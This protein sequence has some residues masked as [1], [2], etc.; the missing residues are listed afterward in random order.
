[1]PAGRPTDCTPELIEQARDYVKDYHVVHGH[2]IPSAVGLCKVINVARST[3]Y[4]WAEEDGSEF[5]DILEEIKDYQH[6]DLTSKGLEGKFNPT[7]TKLML[8][9]HGY[10]DKQDSTLGNADGQPFKTE[11]KWE[12]EFVNAT[13]PSKS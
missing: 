11:G 13:T 2:I 8:T 1:M 5:K 7:I 6:F 4:R 9:K 3:I 10:S 12:I